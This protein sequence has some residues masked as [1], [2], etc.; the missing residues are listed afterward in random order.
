MAEFAE[1]ELSLHRR[2]GATYSIEMRFSQPNSD[3]DVRLGQGEK[4]TVELDIPALQ[5]KI[6][7]PEDYGKALSASLFADAGVLSAFAQARAS[8]QSLKAPLRMRLLAGPSAPELHSLYWETLRDPQDG[9]PLFTSEQLFFSRYLSSTDLRPVRLKAK[10]ELRALV[11]I[12]NPSNLGEYS[13]EAVDVAGELGRA[14]TGLGSIPVTALPGSDKEFCTLN[15]LVEKLREGYDILYLVAHG[16]YAKDQ[17]WLFLQDD[18]GKVGRTAGLELVTRVKELDNPPRLIVLASCQSAGKGAGEA[19]QALGPSLA[20]T[21][22]PAVVAMQGNVFMETVEKFMPVFFT[23]LQKD[24][25]IDRAMAVARG[26]VRQQADFWMPA[27]FMRLKSGRIWYVPGFGDEGGFE[28]WPSLL[29]SVDRGQCTPIIGSGLLEPYLGPWRDI[30][31]RWADKYHY[32]LATHQRDVLPQV[33]QYLAVNQDRHFPY[34]TLEDTVRESLKKRFESA[35]PDDLKQPRAKV[36]SMLSTAGKALREK[37]PTEAHRILAGL[38]LPIYITT[39]Y[40]NLLA[41]ALA[42]AGRKPEVVVCPWNE[43]IDTMASV[44]EKEPDYRP[45]PGRPLVYHLFGRWDNADSLVLTQDD[46]FDFLI[47][48]TS[49]KDLI[50]TA[51]RRALADSALMFIGFQL[52]DWSFRVFYRAIMGQQGGG[53]RSRYAHIGVQIDPDE[54]STSE[55]E[56]ARDYLENYFGDADI[57]IYWGASDDFVKELSQQLAPAAP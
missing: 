43:Y 42:E 56:R 33:A 29:R 44:F 14:R 55:P 36:A 32:P 20:E 49:N 51:V 30:A 9:S 13:L 47:G 26:T 3:A 37:D 27:L 48:L 17:P 39:N 46:Y 40:D 25:Q 35:L 34:D 19:L 1:L 24:G 16:V 7:S 54:S 50:P 18:E 4:I 45:D 41:D 21:G 38:P 5:A 31:R 22:V 8:A 53:R 52:D 11:A 12:A 6:D 15:A 10:G 28:K 23:E 2:E 57:S